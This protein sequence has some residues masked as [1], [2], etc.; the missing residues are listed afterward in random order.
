MNDGMLIPVFRNRWQ[1][2]SGCKPIV[3]TSSIYSEFSLAA[4]MEVWNGFVEWVKY[5]KGDLKPEDRL[6]H[7]QMNGKVIWVIDDQQ[8]Y[9]IMF[10]S[11]Y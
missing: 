2:L 10:P 4:I 6:F 9:T 3:A 7:T 11:D 5:E 1:Q 8:A